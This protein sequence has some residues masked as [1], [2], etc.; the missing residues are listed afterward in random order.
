VIDR[1]IDARSRGEDAGDL[2]RDAGQVA[3]ERS[4]PWVAAHAWV[5]TMSSVVPDCDND[6]TSVSDRS[7]RTA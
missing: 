2:V 3:L 1:G 6:T 7:R 4:A 5:A